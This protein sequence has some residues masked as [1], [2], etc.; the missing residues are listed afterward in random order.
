MF[1]GRV[2]NVMLR[3]GFFLEVWV[4]VNRRRGMGSVYG[5]FILFFFD[6]FYNVIFGI[7]IC[8]GLG[9]VGLVKE[10]ICIF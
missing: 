3:N 9:F 10:G 1:G 4:F 8:V 6:L 7:I 2:L 5:R